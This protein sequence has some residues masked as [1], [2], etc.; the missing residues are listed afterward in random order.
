MLQRTAPFG[1]APLSQPAS[2]P[3]T[4]GAQQSIRGPAPSASA[5]EL[6]DQPLSAAEV[7]GVMPQHQEH[8]VEPDSLC[9]ALSQHN[10]SLSDEDCDV[11]ALP[12]LGRRHQQ[13]SGPCQAA[14]AGRSYQFTVS[15]S[16]AYAVPV[17]HFTACQAGAQPRRSGHAEKKQMTSV[18]MWCHS[19]SLTSPIPRSC[20]LYSYE[21]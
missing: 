6:S 15:Y 8:A 13:Q 18:P 14:T 19:T 20:I 3:S 5:G 1:P 16:A 21:A 10:A 4:P 12:H 9:Q 11:A 7:A 2:Q 17:M